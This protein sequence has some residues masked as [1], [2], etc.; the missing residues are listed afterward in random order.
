VANHEAKEKGVGVSHFNKQG[1]GSK[2][3]FTLAFHHV[4]YNIILKLLKVF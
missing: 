1:T 2:N 4:L 3:V